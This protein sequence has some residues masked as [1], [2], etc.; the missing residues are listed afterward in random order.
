LVK[1]NVWRASGNPARLD[2][3][4]RDGAV[5]VSRNDALMAPSLAKAFDTDRADGDAGVARSAQS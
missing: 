5:V 3:S 1:R 4:R 2:N